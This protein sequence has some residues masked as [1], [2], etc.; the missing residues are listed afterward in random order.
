MWGAMPKIPALDGLRA[1]AAMAVLMFHSGF[2]YAG[3]GSLGVD[4]FFVLSG[5]LITSIAAGEID[6]TGSLDLGRFIERR[7]RRLIPA[8]A[9]LLV[10]Y[11]IAAPYLTP[12]YADR[13]WLDAGLALFYLTN[14]AEAYK[15][16]YGPL[17]HTWSLAVEAHFYLIW[18]FVLLGL[19]RFS[20]GAAAL[21]VAAVWL[22][23]T[24][25]RFGWVEAGGSTDIAYYTTPFHASGLLLGAAV[26]LAPWR[27]PPLQVVGYAGLAALAA[28]MAFA[29]RWGFHVNIPLAEAATALVILNPPKALAWKPFVALGAISYGVYLWHIPLMHALHRPAWWILAAWS[30]PLAAISYFA[31]ERRFMTSR[32]PHAP[33]AAPALDKGTV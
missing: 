2:A 22:A 26:A 6:R 9:A 27:P 10:V 15:P 31:V 1:F 17:S 20:R 12:R 13:R 7:A 23:A 14:F 28:L 8:L 3:A 32:R 16:H 25:F 4:V 19:A 18:P 5:F 33:T 21:A 29:A 24:L 30:I 11:V